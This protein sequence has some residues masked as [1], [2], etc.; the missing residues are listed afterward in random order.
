MDIFSVNQSA[1]SNL[2]SYVL[3]VH[4]SKHRIVISLKSSGQ[5]LCPSLTGDPPH[6]LAVALRQHTDVIRRQESVEKC[7]RRFPLLVL[8]LYRPHVRPHHDLD[9]RAAA[10]IWFCVRHVRRDVEHRADRNRLFECARVQVH[11]A[12]PCV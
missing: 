8:V 5:V 12:R 9:P 1:Q 7:S 11:E 2:L 10:G 6:E 4:T 3:S